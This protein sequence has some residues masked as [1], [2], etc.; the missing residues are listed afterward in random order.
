MIPELGFCNHLKA[1]Q[2]RPFRSSPSPLFSGEN[3]I[4]AMISDK[5]VWRKRRFIDYNGE[6]SSP[7]NGLGGGQSCHFAGYLC[8]FLRGR[9]EH[10]NGQPFQQSAVAP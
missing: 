3:V 8:S 9:L 5:P 4:T 1:A 10:A 7:P 6:E 2:G